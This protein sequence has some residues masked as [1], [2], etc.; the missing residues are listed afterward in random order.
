[1]TYIT[2]TISELMASNVIGSTAVTT[3]AENKFGSV[4]LILLGLFAVGLL[5]KVTVSFVY[6]QINKTKANESK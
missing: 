5:I 6:K 4:L 1:M 3:A 2:P